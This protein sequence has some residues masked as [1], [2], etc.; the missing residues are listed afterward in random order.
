VAVAP[1]DQDRVLA[2]QLDLLGLDLR[3]DRRRLEQRAAGGLFDAPGAAAGEAQIAR[4]GSRILGYHVCDWL[5]PTRDLLLDRGM[6]GD[7]VIDLKAF[8]RAIEEAGFRGP[9]EVEI[10]SR[11]WWD[12]PGQEVIAT[13]IERFRAVC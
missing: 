6:M 1:L 4:A 12:R 11:S 7:G 8:R 2:D 13:S 10:F 3:R 5:A 9:Q